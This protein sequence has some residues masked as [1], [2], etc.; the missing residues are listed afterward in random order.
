MWGEGPWRQFGYA[1]E[2]PDE[3]VLID[4]KS[5]QVELAPQD[6]SLMRGRPHYAHFEYLWTQQHEGHGSC[7]FTIRAYLETE[8]FGEFRVYELSGDLDEDG[9]ELVAPFALVSAKVLE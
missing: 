7:Q 5:T 1:R 8:T 6:K 3:F 2:A 9:Y 4:G